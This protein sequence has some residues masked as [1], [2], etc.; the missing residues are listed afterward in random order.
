MK[1]EVTKRDIQKGERGSCRWCPV[2][3]AVAR[4]TNY[5]KLVL[6]ASDHVDINDKDFNLPLRVQ[7]FIACFDMGDDV[8]PFSFNLGRARAL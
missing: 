4:A 1:I 3:R 2:A 7:R 5:K 6:V 8:K